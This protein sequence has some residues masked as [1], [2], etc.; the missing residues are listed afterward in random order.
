MVFRS[1]DKPSL[2]VVAIVCLVALIITRGS[3]HPRFVEVTLYVV[4]GL[5]LLTA[6]LYIAGLP[7]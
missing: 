5:V 4:M 7:K 2:V 6:V 1:A 3:G